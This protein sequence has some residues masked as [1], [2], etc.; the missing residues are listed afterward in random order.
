MPQPA[1]NSAAEPLGG[2][3]LRDGEAGTDP[4]ASIQGGGA[5]IAAEAFADLVA[6]SPAALDAAIE[7]ARRR[8]AGTWNGMSRD[9]R[10]I[11]LMRA[12]SIV[13]TVAEADR[14]DQGLLPGRGG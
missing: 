3:L 10:A 2:D 7:A 12:G 1:S 5:T 11:E 4:I 8:H 6:S 14:V 9:V 13:T